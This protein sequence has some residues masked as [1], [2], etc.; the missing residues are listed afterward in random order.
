M[1]CLVR[2]VQVL[3][4]ES[5]DSVRSFDIMIEMHKLFKKHPPDV[6]RED[7]PSLE[8][9]DY[10]YRC[11]KTVSDKM[12][13]IQKEKVKDFLRFIS[14]DPKNTENSFIVYIS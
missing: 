12:I 6:L 5:E 8:E 14:T 11:L 9:F 10:V 2:V 3:D 1:R 13:Q 4:K 7:L